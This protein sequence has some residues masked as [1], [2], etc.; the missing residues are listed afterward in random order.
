MPPKDEL[1]KIFE[2]STEISVAACDIMRAAL[3]GAAA[4]KH[5]PILW[6]LMDTEGTP[7]TISGNKLFVYLQYYFCAVV[8]REDGSAVTRP[9]GDCDLAYLVTAA[10]YGTLQFL[11]FTSRKLPKALLYCT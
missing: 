8:Y 5:G 11:S 3:G 2:T 4:F 10:A 1:K 7:A 6:A 9:L